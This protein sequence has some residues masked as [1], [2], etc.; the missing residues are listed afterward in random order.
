MTKHNA[1]NEKA[2]TMQEMKKQAQKCGP[3]ETV[4]GV[5]EAS[6]GMIGASSAG[7]LPRDKHQVANIRYSKKK[8]NASFVDD[9]LFIVMSECKLKDVTVQFVR[10][11]KAAL[12]RMPS[13]AADSNRSH[14]H[15][16]THSKKLTDPLIVHSTSRDP[17]ILPVPKIQSSQRYDY[18]KASAFH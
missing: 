1:R 7:Q 2:S 5:S 3:K 6:G 13:N 12:G 16:M 9:D 14:D 10:D 15:H 11:V 18:G 4:T 8:G 17:Y